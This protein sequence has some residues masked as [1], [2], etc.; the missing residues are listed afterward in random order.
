MLPADYPGQP[1]DLAPGVSC[2]TGNG[3]QT[4]VCFEDSNTCA[5]SCLADRDCAD[6]EVCWAVWSGDDVM[7]G[8][9]LCIGGD[10]TT[11]KAEG[12]A[13][14]SGTEC[15]SG[16]CAGRCDNGAPC[17]QNGN[18]AAGTCNG[19]C[20][21]HCRSNAD[22]ASEA[23]GSAAPQSCGPWPTRIDDSGMGAWVTSC[24][25]KYFN[26]TGAD[27]SACASHED[28][29]SDWCIDAICTTPC[30]ISD[31]CT[32]ALQGRHCLP[33]SFVDDRGEAISSLPFCL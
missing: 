15:N 7:V 25:P 18:C 6:G 33:V 28:C 2:A 31:D 26:G 24:L 16:L 29:R 32:G 14:A 21:A 17:N 3:C 5:R 30:G 9:H 1:F 10:L 8:L 13:C 20:V 11:Y 22:C 19:S 4:G 27:A 12:S 23:A